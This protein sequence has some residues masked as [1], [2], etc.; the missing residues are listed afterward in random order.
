MSRYVYYLRMAELAEMIGGRPTLYSCGTPTFNL[1]NCGK[2]R[3]AIRDLP[4]R[5]PSGQLPRC[6]RRDVGL[7]GTVYVAAA[8]VIVGDLKLAHPA[9]R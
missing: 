3:E 9:Q 5:H 1:P 6:R 8:V 4:V 7:G 2:A